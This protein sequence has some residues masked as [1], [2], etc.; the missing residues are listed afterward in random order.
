MS[1]GGIRQLR[2]SVVDSLE[3]RENK[4]KVKHENEADEMRPE[5]GQ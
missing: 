4:N 2:Q 3:D 5:G 1:V